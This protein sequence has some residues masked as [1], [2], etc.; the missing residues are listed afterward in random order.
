MNRRDFII[1]GG[2]LAAAGSAHALR[3]RRHLSL[4]N[5]RKIADAIP[6]SFGAW[7]QMDT[8]AVIAP[9]SDNSLAA[10][11]YSEQV[12]RLYVLDNQNYVMLLIAYGDTQSDTLQLHRPEVCYPAF[13][14]QV[15][16]STPAEV[17]LAPGVD[18]PAR[19]LTAST[20]DRVEH[21]TYWTRIGEYLPID[22][23]EQ[24]IMKLRTAFQGIIPDGVLVRISSTLPNP[25]DAARLND[26]F[27]AAMIGATRPD[28]RAAL[29]TT[30][31]ARILAQRPGRG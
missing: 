7:H 3:P 26:R 21:I 28:M 1:A 6:K 2:C 10:K 12:S 30:E 25:E 18:I 8:N 29:I 20:P 4:V 22:G 16:D 13:G 9:E 23:D 24:R 31:K 11:L 14:F 5:G 27:A 19:R 15:T 17:L